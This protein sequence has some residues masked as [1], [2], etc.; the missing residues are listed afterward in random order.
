MKRLTRSRL[1]L[2]GAVIATAAAATLTAQ[3]QLASGHALDSSLQ[4]GQ[5][6]YNGATQIG[7]PA[8]RARGYAPYI[9]TSRQFSPYTG[10]GYTNVNQ[11][12]YSNF[13]TYLN[14]RAYDAGWQRSSGGYSSQ[15]ASPGGGSA[16]A[17][18]INTRVGG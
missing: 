6:G 12:R 2:T 3:V 13:D 18:R 15:S 7:G 9:G 5:G 4:L 1:F 10:G 11:G 8:L 16:G 14:G 17:Y